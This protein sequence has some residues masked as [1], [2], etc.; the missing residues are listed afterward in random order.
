MTR[1]TIELPDDV[2]ARIAADAARQHITPEEF[3]T[4]III[5]HFSPPEPT[6]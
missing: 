1:F 3:V 6:E 2:Y 5:E 4:R